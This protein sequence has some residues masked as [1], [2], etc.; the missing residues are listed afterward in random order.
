M[1]IAVTVVVIVV[2][3]WRLDLQATLL[4]ALPRHSLV[5]PMPP[6]AFN[7]PLIREEMYII[8]HFYEAHAPLSLT[9]LVGVNRKL[10][11]WIAWRLQF[12]SSNETAGGDWTQ[13]TKRQRRTALKRELRREQAEEGVWGHELRD[14][15]DFG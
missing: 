2:V 8:D 7:V 9:R 12:S 4:T 11:E 5:A 14:R 6:Y 10:C 1:A 13:N 15:G 3:H